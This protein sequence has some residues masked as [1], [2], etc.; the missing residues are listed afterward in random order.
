MSQIGDNISAP[1]AE[2]V[3][4]RLEQDYGELL[5]NAKNAIADADELP[6]TVE[7]S[8]DVSTI[9][10][11][12][13]KLRDLSARA[14]SHRQA[15][16]EPYLRAGD[17]VYAFFTKRVVDPLDAKRRELNDRLDVYKQR[18]L[19]EE[20]ARREAE[21]AAARKQQEEARRIREEAEAAERR[22]RSNRAKEE[23]AAEAAAARVEDDMATVKAE[24]AILSTMTKPAHMVGERFEGE[25][26]G[27]VTM[28]K[29]TVVYIEDV[30]KLD[31]ERLRFYL[32][33][34]H[35]LMALRAWAK[36]TNYEEAMPGAT[37]ALRETTVVR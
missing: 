2:G 1:Y 25:R 17:A 4:D 19:A 3:S 32:K 9:A 13:K 18:Q 33:E 27:K 23:R 16:K 14:V 35:L 30:A 31:L 36:A 21:A 26:S 28:R 24:E 11:V 37:V 22:A 5:D 7:S 8:I 34:E 10:D 15:E 6:R 29:A 20:R 12:V